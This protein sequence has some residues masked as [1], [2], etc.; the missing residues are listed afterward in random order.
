MKTSSTGGRSVAAF[1]RSPV[2][3]TLEEQRLTFDYREEDSVVVDG[4]SGTT[5]DFAGRAQ[6]GF[7]AGSRLDRVSTRRLF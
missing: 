4:E 7:L 1:G 5:W 2:P 6:D 3:G